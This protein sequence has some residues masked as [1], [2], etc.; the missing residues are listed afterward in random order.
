MPVLIVGAASGSLSWDTL[1]PG[2]TP[3]ATTDRPKP[4]GF[5]TRIMEILWPWGWGVTSRRG[6]PSGSGNSVRN[7]KQTAGRSSHRPIERLD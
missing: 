1:P 2:G 4:R 6:A 5:F 7:E 3:D